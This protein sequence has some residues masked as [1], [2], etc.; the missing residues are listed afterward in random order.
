MSHRTTL[1]PSM[2]VES[3]HFYLLV[4]CFS[5]HVSLRQERTRPRVLAQLRQRGQDL[6]T[7]NCPWSKH[8]TFFFKLTMGKVFLTTKELSITQM[9]M[10]SSEHGGGPIR[11]PLVPKKYKCPSIRSRPDSCT[12]RVSIVIAIEH[13]KL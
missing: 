6:M 3:Q 13:W 5:S 10:R 8:Q 2:C 9:I 7:I 12:Y 4:S 11:T 1:S